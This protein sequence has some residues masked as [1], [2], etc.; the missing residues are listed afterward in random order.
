MREV[1]ILTSPWAQRLAELASAAHESVQVCSPFVN[2]GGVDV[3]LTATPPTTEIRLLS[4]FSAAHFAGGFSETGAFRAVLARGGQVRNCQRLH[5]KVYLFDARCAVVTSGN[6]TGGGLRAN[7]EYGVLLRAPE[8]VSTVDC[9]F[10]RLWD[11]QATGHI[12]AEV[13]AEIDELVRRAP[14]VCY[15]EAAATRDTEGE[16]ELVL[17][18]AEAAIRDT[19]TG[20]KRSVFQALTELEGTEFALAQVYRYAARFAREY[21]DNENIE[22]KIRQQLQMLRDLGLV[23]FLG[24]GRYRKLWR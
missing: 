16:A 21:P 15:V 14:R 4:R 19:L 13:L 7:Y 24:G 18:E 6:L 9:D 5:A 20:W 1:E 11:D 17:D 23:K 22:A 2:R 12:D 3:L 8:L 10:R